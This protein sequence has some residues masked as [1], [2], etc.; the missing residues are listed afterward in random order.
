M[1]ALYGE[2]EKTYATKLLELHLGEPFA[3]T[4][5]EKSLHFPKK[6]ACLTSSRASLALQ[7][8]QKIGGLIN[9]TNSF[10]LYDMDAL[11]MSANNVKSAFSD[12]DVEFLHC[13]AMKSCP[14]SFILKFLL[15]QGLGMEAASYGELAQALRC[16]CPPEKIVYDAPCKDMK[17]LI[18][19]LKHGVRVN[20]NSFN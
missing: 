20:V 11:L 10:V 17:E 2:I 15:D 14:V 5:R 19:A 4:R 9:E 7:H 13:Y 18:F 8:L 6:D 16:G 12:P 1:T 3:S